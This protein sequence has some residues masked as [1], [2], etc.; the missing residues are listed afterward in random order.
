MN[1]SK[2]TAVLNGTA[3]ML[4]G[5]T[6]RTEGGRGDS[7]EAREDA[8]HMTD[9]AKGAAVGMK[10]ASMILEDKGFEVDS[11]ELYDCVVRT[12]ADILGADE[13]GDAA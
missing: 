5:T 10:A 2:T 12:F 7:E 13:G 6:V 3:R 9:L 11:H 4:A 8:R 1:R